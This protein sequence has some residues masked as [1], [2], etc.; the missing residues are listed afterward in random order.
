MRAIFALS[1]LLALFVLSA[2]NV[3]AMDDDS[4]R[5]KA[6]AG[7][8]SHIKNMDKNPLLWGVYLDNLYSLAD[9]EK[10]VGKQPDI[11]ATFI[12]WGNNKEFPGDIAPIVKDSDKTLLIYWEAMDYNDPSPVQPR[13][14]YD[15][16]LSGYWDEYIRSFAN[17]ARAYGGPVILVPF[18]EMNGDWSAWSGTIN[19]NSAEKH[20][21]AYRRI[22]TV[23]RERKADN[24]KFGWAAN[25][26]DVP[27][28]E[29]NRFE[30]YYPGDEYVDYIG[31]DGFN[32]D[33]PWQNWDEVFGRSLKRLAT[34][35]DK[36]IFIFSTAC[37]EGPKK[38]EWIRKG[39][40]SRIKDYPQ[41]IGWIW[42]NE[43]KEKDWR[44][45]SDSESLSV[46]RDVVG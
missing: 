25:N 11:F 27:E 41:V 7:E 24:V 10:K 5:N 13:F 9:F 22:R 14:N 18:T 40:G 43:K 37:A 44:P 20:I 6:A 19:N 31:V 36:P 29:A 16:V 39:L 28:T 8:A 1:A 38:P 4:G 35:S 33:D 26:D 12:H 2:A 21:A 46:F 45:D 23:F 42:F 15:S 17:D 30:N 3:Y 34:M 32:F